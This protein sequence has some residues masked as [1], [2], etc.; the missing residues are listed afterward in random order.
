[1]I[2]I[3]SF[4]FSAFAT[5]VDRLELEHTIAIAIQLLSKLEGNLSR[6]TKQQRNLTTLTL[7]RCRPQMDLFEFNI[8]ATVQ[9]RLNNNTV[10]I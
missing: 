3:S 1:M 7:R 10:T 4:A 2:M 6:P 8:M 5:I 9:F